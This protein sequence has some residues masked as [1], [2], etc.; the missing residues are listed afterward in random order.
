MTMIDTFED[1]LF[2]SDIFF[3]PRLERG[4]S[5]FG[6]DPRGIKVTLAFQEEENFG[7]QKIVERYTDL[8]VS[9]YE[10]EEDV[11]E[12]DLREAKQALDKLVERLMRSQM[13]EL[14]AKFPGLR[15]GTYPVGSWLPEEFLENRYDFFVDDEVAEI[16][17]YFRF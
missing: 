16:D 3:E 4:A 6:D 17:V 12:K 13:Q 14:H 2:A 1:I 8:F 11:D 5:T 10:D 15:W 7:N 9:K